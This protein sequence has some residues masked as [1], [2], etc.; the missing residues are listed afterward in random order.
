MKGRLVLSTGLHA[1]QAYHQVWGSR[2]LM[3]VVIRKRHW[4][5]DERLLV[6]QESVDPSSRPW[7]IASYFTGRQID[8][9]L[10]PCIRY[11]QSRYGTNFT[12]RCQITA[13]VTA[14]P[15]N[16]KTNGFAT[17]ITNNIQVFREIE[18]RYDINSCLRH[19][20]QGRRR[21]RRWWFTLAGTVLPKSARKWN[22]IQLDLVF[23]H[24]GFRKLILSLV[25]FIV[26][27]AL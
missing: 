7:T 16:K 17:T 3:I 23:I 26:R 21:R 8:A 6:L 19:R 24:I 14:L 1:L 20:A 5:I 12:D 10:L 25:E 2:R 13:W 4:S 18:R 22:A 11:C 27:S 15:R 9:A